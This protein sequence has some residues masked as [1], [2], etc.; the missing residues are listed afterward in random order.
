MK[1]FTKYPIHANTIPLLQRCIF[2]AEDVAMLLHQIK[3]L[4]NYTISASEI[5]GENSIEFA[6]GD[7]IYTAILDG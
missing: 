5:P 7:D 2:T 1:K 3:Q 6:I 4:R